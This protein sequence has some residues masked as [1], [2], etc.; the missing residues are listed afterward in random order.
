MLSNPMT[1]HQNQN[2]FYNLCI[3]LP[4]VRIS[5]Y[6]VVLLH[7][8]F[9]SLMISWNNFAI[10]LSSLPLGRFLRDP[11][12]I[13]VSPPEN[14][15]IFATKN[16]KSFPEGTTL[17]IC[18]SGQFYFC[19]G[20]ALEWNMWG[21]VEKMHCFLML[22]RLQWQKVANRLSMLE[23]YLYLFSPAS[24]PD[25]AAGTYHSDINILLEQ[26][27]LKPLQIF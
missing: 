8:S 14:L 15:P 25:P 18:W 26:S 11:Y 21:L 19:H 1:L 2:N 12:W 3:L 5:W 10:F 20:A 13:L 27:L 9:S 17:P 22:P 16:C 4:E 24:F 6:L 23:I 7:Y